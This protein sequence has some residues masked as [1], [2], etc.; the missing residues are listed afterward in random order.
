MSKLIKNSIIYTGTNLITA[1][2]AFI[3]LP[4]Y[5]SYLSTEGFGIVSSMQ[6]FAAIL[7]IFMTLAIE[8]S[9]F[10]IYYDYNDDEN[11]KMFLGTIFTSILIIGLSVTILAFIFSNLLNFIFPSINFYPFYALTIFYAFALSLFSFIKSIQQLKQ[12]AGLFASLSLLNFFLIAVITLYYLVLKK[13]GA[14]GYVKAMLIG[15]FLSAIIAFWFSKG[16]LKLTFRSEYLIQALKYSA[17]MLPSL[18]SAWVLNLS[19]RIFIDHNLSQSD[20]GIYSLAFRISSI[21]ILTSSA[22]YSAYSPMFF[23]KAANLSNIEAKQFLRKTNSVF[24]YIIGIICLV[25]FLF[26]KELLIMFFQ[27]KYLPAV[28][29]IKLFCLSF[30]I[31]QITG[32]LNL[33]YY[34]IKKTYIVTIAICLSALVNIALNAIFIPR[35]GL[36]AAVIN[37]IVASIINFLILLLYSKSAYFIKLP[38]E[39]ILIFFV[40]MLSLNLLSS[41]DNIKFDLLN[42]VIKIII[43]STFIIFIL[44]KHRTIINTILIDALNIIRNYKRDF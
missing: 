23:E 2:S 25:I 16:Y 1:L 12:N 41:D 27:P 18:L 14:E 34:Q 22:F 43:L 11:K 31:S 9:I 24:I 38:F 4:I 19:D 30:F 39:A 36:N 15:T 3:L 20:L 26:S 29:L 13:D 6:T 7:T 42:L 35:F 40:S 10:R 28:Q 5:T 37:S 44:L 33:M 8:Q 17:P 32:L 21:I